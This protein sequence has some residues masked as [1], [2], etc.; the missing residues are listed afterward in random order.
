LAAAAVD[1]D[2]APL[3]AGYSLVKPFRS[4]V[5]VKLPSVRADSLM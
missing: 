4:L 1:D 2:R 3:A 5:I